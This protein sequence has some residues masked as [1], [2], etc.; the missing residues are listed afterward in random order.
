MFKGLTVLA[1]GYM[2][3]LQLLLNWL[4]KICFPSHFNIWFNII[5]MLLLNKKAYNG[6]PI[7]L[8]WVPFCSMKKPLII[9]QFWPR[10]YNFN[11]FGKSLL[12]IITS[13]IYISSRACRF[14][15]EDF[16]ELPFRLLSC[17]ENPR[18]Q[19]NGILRTYCSQLHGWSISSKLNQVWSNGFRGDVSW[20]NCGWCT[21]KWLTAINLKSSNSTEVSLKNCLQ[22]IISLGTLHLLCEDWISTKN[23]KKYLSVIQYIINCYTD[24]WMECSN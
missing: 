14:C 13:H 20:N 2:L 23:C 11:K 8:T 24:G 21:A 22:F 7:S 5:F 4:I 12:K 15:K 10:V 6:G 16:F 9:N 1:F 19:R 17:H 3:H 18:S